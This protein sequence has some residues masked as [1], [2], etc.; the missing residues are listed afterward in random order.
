MFD[1]EEYNTLY[2]RGNIQL[3]IEDIE[4]DIFIDIDNLLNDRF[5]R[6]FHWDKFKCSDHGIDIIYPKISY[7]GNRAFIKGPDQIRF[8]LSLYP[9]KER[10][11]NIDKIII[12]PRYVEI[13]KVELVSIYI[14]SERILVL[15]L[16]RPH[17]YSSNDTEL[18]ETF[19]SISQLFN[20]E[21]LVNQKAGT[22]RYINKI[23]PLWY[24]LS[25]ISFS[26]EN[27]IDKFFIKNEEQE[28]EI[29][30]NLDKT[31]LFYSRHGY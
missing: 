10:L 11:E 15:Y 21:L 31:S 14:R 27:R 5:S 7:P 26:P 4:N 9:K 23:P 29:T 18:L 28:R 20:Y 17:L 6:L 30:E 8:L 2:N 13:N 1:I 3:E 12:Q 19:S 24:I 16:H 25:I 22:G